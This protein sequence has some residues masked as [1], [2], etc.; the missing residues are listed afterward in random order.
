MKLTL[1]D[2]LFNLLDWL[3]GGVIYADLSRRGWET[4]GQ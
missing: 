1:V 2:G 4:V 3:G